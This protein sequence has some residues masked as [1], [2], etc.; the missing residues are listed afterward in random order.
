VAEKSTA[1]CGVEDQFPVEG[2]VFEAFVGGRLYPWYESTLRGRRTLDYVGEYDR[3]QWMSADELQAL[4]LDKLRRL[5]AHCQQTV[6]YY[7]RRWKELGLNWQDVRSQADFAQLPMIGKDDIRAHYAE[8]VSEPWHGKTL[9]KTTGGSTGRPFSF[10]YT[11][12][13][14]ERRMAVMMRGYAWAGWRPGVRRLDI[15]GTE[16]SVQSLP[17]RLK[18]QAFDAVMGRRVL[19]CFEM[20]RDNIGEFVAE[21]DRYRPAV[22][23]GYTGA[24]ETMAT[25][26]ENNRGATWAPGAVITAA[27]MLSA[28]QRETI[29]R[30]FR[31]PVF[32]TYGC[33]EFMLIGAECAEH[34]GYHASADHLVIEVADDAGRTVSDG[35]G[36]IVITDLHN[37]GM[38]FIRC[39][40]GDLIR[41]QPGAAQCRCGR[42]LPLIGAVEG[43]RLDILTTPDGRFIPGEFF[44]HL[45]KDVSTIEAFQ[46]RQTRADQ[47]VVLIVKTA[48]IAPADWAYLR[49]AIDKVVGSEMKVEFRIVDD[50]PLTPSGKRRVAVR[51]IETAA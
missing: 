8:F 21:I 29:E 46:V 42:G 47:L 36:N 32:H 27:E 15:W 49:S 16:L 50:I 34:R 48:D 17:R 2:H 45:I 11:R 23:V 7:R 39:A 28:R 3:Q 37:L 12:E 24:L 40:N 13:S 44:P 1:F 35:P 41:A 38:P 51:E 14:Y 4:Q 22:I 5:L 25:W 33:R 20:H 19:S 18:T 31:A 6:P 43:R 30:S 10:E 9:K 26:I